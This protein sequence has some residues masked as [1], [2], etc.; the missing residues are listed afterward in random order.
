MLPPDERR[1]QAKAAFRE[2]MW[3]ELTIVPGPFYEVGLADYVFGEIWNRRGL[4]RKSRRF[5]TLVCTAATGIPGSVAS[6][7]YGSLRSGDISFESML[8]LA[9]QAAVYLG[10]PTASLLHVATWEQAR[11]I[12]AE[13]GTG[14]PPEFG[15]PT[16]GP[17][18]SVEARLASGAR[19][20]AEV[21]PREFSES[22]TPLSI[23]GNLNFVFGE[24]WQRPGLTLR[25]RRIVTLSCVALSNVPIAVRTH[26]DSAL[27]SGDVTL[28]EMREFAL[29]FA[30]YAGLPRGISLDRAIDEIW[31]DIDRD[32][33]P[34]RGAAADATPEELGLVGGSC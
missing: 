25:D 10:W 28:R 34:R 15:Q 16:R 18:L 7:V 6:H 12:A 30:A 1:Q 4:S 22:V 24:V 9:L 8:E 19:L 5:V 21:N 29:H 17:E 23:T 33:G 3:T 14:S 2:I 27:R 20:Y 26:L 11:R 32:G 13:D 31:A